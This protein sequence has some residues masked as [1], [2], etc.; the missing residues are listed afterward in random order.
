MQKHLTGLI[1]APYTAMH[2]DGSINLDIVSSQAELLINNNVSGAFVCGTTG[3]GLSLNIEERMKIA[4][5]WQAVS[6]KN[7]NVI[8]HV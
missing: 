1:A 6:G 4:E 3:E 5:R 8:V 2:D 7:L